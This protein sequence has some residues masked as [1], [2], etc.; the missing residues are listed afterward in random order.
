[1]PTNLYGQGDNFDLESSHVLPALLRK[2]H[3]AKVAGAAAV[4]LWGSGSALREFL[5]V[6][7]LAS[8]AVFLMREYSSGEIINVGSGDVVSIGELARLIGEVVGFEGE[9]VWDRGKPDGTP[10]KLMDSGRLR[11]MGWRPEIGLRDGV[12]RTYEWFCGSEAGLAKPA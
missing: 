12:R 10:R 6:D 4:T 2:F 7:D 9:I 8:A 11:G 1:M 5:H 3:E